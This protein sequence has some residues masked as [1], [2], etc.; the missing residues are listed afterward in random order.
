MP[1]PHR[2][3]PLM[4]TLG[5]EIAKITDEILAPLLEAGVSA[6]T[7]AQLRSQLAVRLWGLVLLALNGLSNS[8]LA[9]LDE[10]IAEQGQARRN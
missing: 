3:E 1:A 10:M 2:T 6:E 9:A 7:A 8:T 4:T 5:V